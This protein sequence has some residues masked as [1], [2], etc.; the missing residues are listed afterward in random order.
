MLDQVP[1][2]L[3]ACLCE[4]P[5][6]GSGEECEEEKEERSYGQTVIPHSISSCSSWGRSKVEDLE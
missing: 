6:F 3:K 2:F 4:L 1:F 5:H